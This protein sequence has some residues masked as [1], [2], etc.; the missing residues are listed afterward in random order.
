[1]PHHLWSSCCRTKLMIT[2][3]VIQ[4][5]ALF[6]HINVAVRIKTWKW[7]SIFNKYC[8]QWALSRKKNRNLFKVQLQNCL[9]F[10]YDEKWIDFVKGLFQMQVAAL[11]K[12][13]T[14]PSLIQNEDNK[15]CLFI[16]YWWLALALQ[17]EVQDFRVSHSEAFC[18][19]FSPHQPWISGFPVS[20]HSLA[21]YINTIFS[22]FYVL[23]C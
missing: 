7:N 2:L 5:G 1:M 23:N 21:I 9:A 18:L 3:S 6:C 8:F 12:C 20:S 22:T 17:Q 16:Y 10:I 13:T 14:K 15:F 19:E 4:S 11:Q